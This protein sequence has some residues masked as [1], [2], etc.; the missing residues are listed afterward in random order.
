VLDS[1]LEALYSQLQPP[2]KL[3]KLLKL[4]ME[5]IAKRRKKIAQKEIKNLKRIIGDLENKEIKLIDEKLEGK[6]EKDI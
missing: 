1:Q 2:K 5:E 3:L 6:V 4:E